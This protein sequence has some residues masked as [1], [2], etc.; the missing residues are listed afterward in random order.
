MA[1]EHLNVGDECR[2][3]FDINEKGSHYIGGGKIIEKNDNHFVVKFKR[4]GSV[5]TDRSL[6][7]IPKEG[8]YIFPSE[9]NAK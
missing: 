5:Y 3:C 6:K 8:F 9:K 7:Y 2:V 4:I 1:N